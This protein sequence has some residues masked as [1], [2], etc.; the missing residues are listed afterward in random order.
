MEQALFQTKPAGFRC[1][2]GRAGWTTWLLRAATLFFAFQLV[3]PASAQPAAERRIALVIGIGDYQAAPKLAN[4]V[5]D[6]RLIG[7][8]LRTLGF[9]V[10]EIYDTDYRTLAQAIRAFG[11]KAQHSDVALVY[12]AGHGVQVGRENYLLPADTRLE[13]ERDLLYEAIPLELLLGEVSQANKLAIVMLD[14]C[15]N[16]PFVER[17]SRSMTLAGRGATTS[18]LARVDNVPRNTVVVMAT[19]ADQ[20]AEDGAGEHSPF[21]T[22]LQANLATPDLELS[23]FFRSVRDGVLKAT[24]G[25]QEPYVFSSVG[26]E[27]FYLHPRPP[28]QPP[29]LGSMAPLEVRD[30]AGPTPLAIGVPKSPDRDPLTV[31][32]TGLPH[33]GEVQVDGRPVQPG[34]T[35]AAERIAGATYKPELGR[36]GPVGTFD[37]L[38]EGSSGSVPGSMA[39]S[40]V[41]LNR[42]PVVEPP[43][44]LRIYTGG[45]D[46][47]RPESPDGDPLTVLVTA[48]P[49]GLVRNG[50]SAVR[51]G[52]HLPPEALPLLAFVPEPGFAGAAGSFGYQVDNGRGSAVSSAV[53]LD[54][55]DASEAAGQMAEA[56][57]WNRVRT[58]THAEDLDAFTRFYP[59]SRF[60]TAVAQRR[61]DLA[62]H[63]DEPP[64]AN[65]AR[66]DRSL[67]SLQA[68]PAA[69]DVARPALQR[70]ALQLPAQPS[71][72]EVPKPSPPTPK[73]DATLGTDA[74]AK[75]DGMPKSDATAKS[76]ERDCPTCP[77]LVGVPGGSFVMGLGAKDPA[78]LPQHRVTLRPFVMGQTPV[79]IADWNACQA[80]GGCGPAP[81]MSVADDATPLHNASWDDAQQYLAWLSRVAGRPYRL[82]TEAEWEYAARGKA[83]TRYPWGDQ[84]G[85]GLANCAD[86]GGQ[87]DPHAPAPALAYQPNSFG[88]YGM[89][90][91]VAQWVQDCWFPTYAGASLEGT[92]REARGCSQ[93]VLRGGSFRS[94]HDDITPTARNR[95][96]ASVRYF[97]NGFR[98][99]R[100]AE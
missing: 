21:A 4:P 89:S 69:P 70:L 10:D 74:T 58:S 7:G 43:R 54:V 72:P 41:H 82:P 100:N 67:A 68:T 23:L 2:P 28:S 19:K 79:T 44:R 86:C 84:L 76:G 31:R 39:V 57:L 9:D 78:A 55:M 66:A 24:N 90:G 25:R 5:R 20:V 46:I 11:I 1:G 91:G 16:N 34:A 33:F 17:M 35:F 80:D 95:Y 27:P 8:S 73:P 71:Q 37:I 40:V 61:M 49:R 38:V 92:A 81:H 87:Q 22:A 14:A 96:D 62:G 47:R 51:L 12:Y 52:D 42:P 93:H 18:G 32:I 97:T 48:L 88:L 53:E 99:A 30:T 36:T 15:R 98:V 56:A 29:V 59:N 3:G 85:V 13:R 60:G 94:T 6:A 77:V 45:L 26:A 63:G 50:L 83:S 65:V 75:S 64:A